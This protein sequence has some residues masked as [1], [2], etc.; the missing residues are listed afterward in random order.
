ME[1]EIAVAGA[2][3]EPSGTP[4]EEGN[5]EVPALVPQEDEESDDEAEESESEDEIEEEDKKQSGQTV[6]RSECI[7]VGATRQVCGSY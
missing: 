2:K 4:D 5:D 7:K 1:S 3:E 6:R